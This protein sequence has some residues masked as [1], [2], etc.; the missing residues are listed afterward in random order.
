VWSARQVRVVH[1]GSAS[2]LSSASGCRFSALP[3]L[4]GIVQDALKGSDGS[5]RETSAATIPAEECGACWNRSA[6]EC[7]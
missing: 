2:C 3:S 7:E 5:L 6:A 4:P 1:V